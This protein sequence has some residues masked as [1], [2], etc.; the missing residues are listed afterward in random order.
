MTQPTTLPIFDLDGIRK[1][2]ENDKE[3][4]LS[5]YEKLAD[6]ALEVIRN[7]A[8]ASF[9]FGKLEEGTINGIKALVFRDFVW[10]TASGTV[11]M[12]R[13]ELWVLSW[14]DLDLYTKLFRHEDVTDNLRQLILM[15]VRDYCLDV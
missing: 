3:E 5:I 8:N 4:N 12:D 6:E 1:Q 15:N 13:C 10:S 14:P 2:W 11:K 9:S 7:G